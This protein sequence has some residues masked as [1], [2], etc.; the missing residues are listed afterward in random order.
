[1]VPTPEGAVGL[2]PVKKK[3]KKK[4]PPPQQQRE[5]L[6]NCILCRKS[7]SRP[8]S[9]FTRMFTCGAALAHVRLFLIDPMDPSHLLFILSDTGSTGAHARD[10][11]PQRDG[12]SAG[13]VSP[14]RQMKTS[15]SVKLMI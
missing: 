6:T 3:V 5:K 15:V 2:K 12:V 11:A 9:D 4:P 7:F 8:V 10:A 1:M 14:V 13:Q